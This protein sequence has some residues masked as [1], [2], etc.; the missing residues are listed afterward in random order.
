MVVSL[1]L[2]VALAAISF[3]AADWMWF[4]IN[5]LSATLLF[6]PRWKK[7]GYYSSKEFDQSVLK[8]L[9]SETAR[10]MYFSTDDIEESGI[11]Q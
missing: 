5:I 10:K 4:C 6:L 7:L 3:L 1:V 9:E 11:D 2:A 8:W